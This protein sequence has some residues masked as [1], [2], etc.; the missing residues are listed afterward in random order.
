MFGESLLSHRAVTVWYF[1]EHDLVSYVVMG[2]V[3]R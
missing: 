2:G 3:T 1:P